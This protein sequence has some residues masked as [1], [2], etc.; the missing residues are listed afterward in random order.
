[1]S[2]D[3]VIR[4]KYSETLDRFVRIRKLTQDQVDD[5]FA[6][7]RL[8]G[9][10]AYR[11]LIVT[12]TVV[13]FLCDMAPA[14]YGNDDRAEVCEAV[15]RDL[16]ELAVKVNPGLDINE[17]T[18]QV[19]QNVEDGRP[20]TVLDTS[21]ALAPRPSRALSGLAAGLRRR[22]VGQDEAVET[23][24]AIVRRAMAGL[25][26]PRRP[27]GSFIFV[28]QTGVGKTELARVLADALFGDPAALVRVDCS[29]FAMPHEYAKLIG[30]PP[31]YVG[32]GEGGFLTE[33]I[34]RRPASVVVFDEIEK[35]DEK[36]RNLLLQILDEGVL[37][38][39][40][41]NRIS[42]A[43]TIVILT[44][45]VGV[46]RLTGLQKAVGFK[47]PSATDHEVRVRETGKALEASFPPEFLNRVDEIVTFRSL[48]R[49]D[50]LAI[51]ALQLDEVVRRA[52]ALG[53]RLVV[54]P[55]A[56]EFLVESGT[57]RR[58][59]ARPL[60]R[61]IRRWVEMPLADMIVRAR[62]QRGDVVTAGFRTNREKLHFHVTTVQG[63][64]RR[65]AR[66]RR[67]R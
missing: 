17:V 48:T 36:V 5:L 32:H 65:D 60:Q 6:H 53:I 23:V 15:E 50:N 42:F 47:T 20:A 8:E 3:A 25:Q 9:R 39:G 56:R 1:M 64:K 27:V 33:A 7:A 19:A 26:D 10:R 55:R 66:R 22:V 38:D 30:A 46:E 14:L 16:Y 49:A 54:T 44:S 61:A 58:Y 51:V 57:D 29:E 59:G 21:T 45:N 12:A 4:M 18:L 62:V 67:P 34:R 41:G 11:R 40:K 52:E 43:E 31:G 37:T 13:D 35:A 2:D 24:A 28:G 63:S